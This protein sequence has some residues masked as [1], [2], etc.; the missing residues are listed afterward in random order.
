MLTIGTTPPAVTTPRVSF[1]T[2]A[3][4]M[5][6]ATPIAQARLLRGHKY[7]TDGPKRSYQGVRNQMVGYAVD[8]RP[9]DPNANLR[10]H[11]R[12][13]VIA[14]SQHPVRI[15]KGMTCT[16]PSTR[17]P[18]WRFC[19]VDISV[20]PDVDMT[21]QIGIGGLKG[22][23]AQDPLGHGVGTCMAALLCHYKGTVLG[24]TQVQSR[25]CLVYEARTG[26]VHSASNSTRVLRTAE[27]AC[28]LIV[29]LWPGL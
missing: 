19:G 7:P 16:R 15:P 23:F 5:G 1:S 24:Q 14:M 18:Y 12:D 29:A 8:G 25:Y 10:P 9:I 21:G 13:A 17:A 28:N 11:E 22:Y 4:I 26:D 6:A 27:A 3:K 20:F 2:L